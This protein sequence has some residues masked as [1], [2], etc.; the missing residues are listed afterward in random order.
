MVEGEGRSTVS[1]RLIVTDV[2]EI[3]G[4]VQDERD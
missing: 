3:L 2:E 1:G 4:N